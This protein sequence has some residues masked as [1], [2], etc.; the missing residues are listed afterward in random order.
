[1]II[2]RRFFKLKY[3]GFSKMGCM[4]K[5]VTTTILSTDDINRN[6]VFPMEHKKPNQLN[7][8]INLNLISFFLIINLSLSNWI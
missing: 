6:T 1:M 4:Y 2:E 3:L 7:K 5:Y 8:V